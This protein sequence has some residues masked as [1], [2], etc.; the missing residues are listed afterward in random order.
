MEIDGITLWLFGGVA[1][2]KGQFPSA[3]AEFRIAVTGPLVSLLIGG[4]LT[5]LGLLVRLPAAVDGVV[6]W[7]GYINLM[8]LAFNL[9][10]ALPLDGGRIARSALWH[11]RGDFRSATR[12]AAGSGAPSARS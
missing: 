12:I 3:G 6:T 10:P 1:A 8:L 5:A 7:L 11:F 4:L 9:L 2:F